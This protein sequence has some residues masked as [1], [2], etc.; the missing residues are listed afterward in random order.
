MF[1]TISAFCRKNVG[2]ITMARYL[3]GQSGNP[4]G[5]KKGT[6][7][8]HTQLAKLLEPHA[9]KLVTKAVEMALNGDPQALR[10]CIERLIPRATNDTLVIQ[11]PELNM[12]KSNATSEICTNVLNTLSGKEI[13]FD[14]AKNLIAVLNYCKGNMSDSMNDPDL[15]RAKEVMKELMEKHKREY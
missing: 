1:E 4:V 5:K 9:E 7:N 13:G 11:L 10:L 12:A 8:K 15:Q 3:P 14:Q 2:G 6:L